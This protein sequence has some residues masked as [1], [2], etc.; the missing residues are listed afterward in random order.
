MFWPEA[1][2]VIASGS[3]TG[4]RFDRGYQILSRNYFVQTK[5][6][7][8]T[9][10]ATSIVSNATSHGAF[11]CYSVIEGD[12]EAFKARSA[13]FEAEGPYGQLLNALGAR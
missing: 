13:A 4:K 6:E 1:T 7:S 12:A 9:Q 3:Y 5:Q 10:E 8:E 2:N 11:D